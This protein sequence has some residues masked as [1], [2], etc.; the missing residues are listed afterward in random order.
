M[1]AW[2]F[3]SKKNHPVSW[4][5]IAVIV[6]LMLVVYGIVQGIY[7]MS[8]VSFLFAG[9]YLLMENN[10][11]PTTRVEVTDR[12]IQ[13]GGSFYDY[14]S[15]SKFAIISI[16]D[17][18]TFIRLT[19]NK[20]LSPLIDIPLSHDVNPVE[21]RTYLASVMQEDKNT[22]ISNADAIIHAMKL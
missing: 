6:V 2:S 11:T 21:L 17:V 4:Y 16:G 18:P 1:F 14:A 20:K 8:I 10:A 3:A 7:I 22:T 13:V 19:P 15:F 5:I 12:G 9:V